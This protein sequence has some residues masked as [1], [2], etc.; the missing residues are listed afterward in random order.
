VPATT[1]LAIDPEL[2]GLELDEGRQRVAE[3]HAHAGP[4]D[5][6]LGLGTPRGELL[7][8]PG[9]DRGV[10]WRE[11]FRASRESERRRCLL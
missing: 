5:A 6:D 3:G 9:V 11:V 2:D 4:I 7:T 8:D 1:Q 10:P